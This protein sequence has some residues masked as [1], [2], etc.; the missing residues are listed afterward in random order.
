MIPFIAILH[1]SSTTKSAGNT[2]GEH[3]IKEPADNSEN[4][5]VEN[6]TSE[7]GNDSETETVESETAN[8]A[9]QSKEKPFYETEALKTI[10]YG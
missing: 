8:S 6:D 1:Y 7:D 4:E 5:T 9:H 2:C 3:L 10:L